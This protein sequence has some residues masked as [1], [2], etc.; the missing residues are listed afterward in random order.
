MALK[1]R[2]RTVSDGQLLFSGWL[3]EWIANKCSDS[4]PG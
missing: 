3:F 4:E 2:P 1:I